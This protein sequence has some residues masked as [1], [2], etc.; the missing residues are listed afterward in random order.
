MMAKK[1]PAPKKVA[2]KTRKKTAFKGSKK[3]CMVGEE[4][5]INLVVDM[6]P[7]KSLDMIE[8][9]INKLTPQ[10]K[11]RLLKKLGVKFGVSTKLKKELQKM[12]QK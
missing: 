10:Y 8:K 2:P 1:G 12:L 7:L 3:T 5:I 9:I 11:S 6:T 4:S